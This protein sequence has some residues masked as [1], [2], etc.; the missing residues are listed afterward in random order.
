[1]AYMQLAGNTCGTHLTFYGIYHWG[2]VLA[3][4]RNHFFSS[5]GGTTNFTGGYMPPPSPPTSHLAVLS[6]SKH[7][8]KVFRAVGL[9]WF[10]QLA[11]ETGL[12]LLVD[13]I[14]AS[15]CRHATD[16]TLHCAP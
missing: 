15:C 5:M 4:P 3:S 1:M 7:E 9:T 6:D 13:Q 12:G 16:A 14:N 2:D 10:C 8:I 11:R